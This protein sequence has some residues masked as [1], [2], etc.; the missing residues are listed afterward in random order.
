[1]IVFVKC[2]GINKD[3]D[4]SPFYEN[5]KTVSDMLEAYIDYCPRTFEY[6][7]DEDELKLPQYTPEEQYISH[8]IHDIVEM[9]NK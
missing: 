7:I 5:L 8:R 2:C 9:T 1:M 4:L 6:E 3:A